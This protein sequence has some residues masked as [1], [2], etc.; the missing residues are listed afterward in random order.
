[1]IQRD[2]YLNQVQKAFEFIPIVVLIGSRQVGKTTIMNM[3]K[4]DKKHVSLN[5]QNVE[6]AALFEKNST[7]ENYLRIHLN[8]SFDGFLI[9]DEF[10]FIRAI[11]NTL[12]TLTD[13]NKNIKVLASGSS[14]LDIIQNVHESLA[15]RVRLIRVY[16][17]SF[18]EYILF[19][20]ESLHA[21]FFKYDLYTPSAI[22]NKEIHLLQEE[23]LLYGGMPRVALARSSSDKIQLIDDIYQTYLLR[24]VKSYVRIEDSTGFNKMLRLL[25]A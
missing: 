20:S 4:A 2:K 1:M 17:L 19:N 15:G 6:E 12:K 9:I 22:I 23:Y 5:G 18:Q 14:S 7:I 8:D 24:D 21:E 16:S 11:S 3:F 13:K 25:S 10:Q